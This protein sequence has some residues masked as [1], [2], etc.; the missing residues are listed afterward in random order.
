MDI[1]KAIGNTS[2]VRLRNVVPAGCAR[3]FAKLEW[4]NPTG[5]MKDRMALAVISQAEADGRLRPGGTVVE[6][7]GGSTGTSLALVCAAKGYRIRIVTSDAFSRE[8]RDHMTALGAELTLVSSEGGLTTRKLI[9]DMIETAR[10]MSAEPEHV[11]DQPA[12]EP[13]Q[14]R[15]LLWP[16]R[17]DLDADGRKSR[18]VR[19]LRRHRGLVARRRD[20]AQAPPPG[21][22]HRHRRA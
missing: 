22:P 1:L 11:L 7:T 3:V 19:P 6:Y 15:G 2:I 16:R 9:L 17:R 20:R 18:R 12:R 14:H 4:E 8:K 10:T 21:S 13:R 5:S